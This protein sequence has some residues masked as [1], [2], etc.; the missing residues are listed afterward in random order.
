MKL[1]SAPLTCRCDEIAEALAQDAY[2]N[3]ITPPE[4]SV[5]GAVVF[6][7]GPTDLNDQGIGNASTM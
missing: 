4:K 2:C 7:R 1:S 3:P 6:R 5:Q